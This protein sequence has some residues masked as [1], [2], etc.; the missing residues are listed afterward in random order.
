MSELVLAVDVSLSMSPAELE[1]QRQG[2]AAAL[3]HEQVIEAIRDS[4]NGRIAVTHDEWAGQ[5]TLYIV[6]PWT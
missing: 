2:Y 3:T 6:V 4:V 1:L 5:T